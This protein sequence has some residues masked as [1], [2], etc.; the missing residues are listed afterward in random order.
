MR[1]VSRNVGEIRYA[2]QRIFSARVFEKADF[3]RGAPVGVARAAD[4]EDD[5]REPPRSRGVPRENAAAGIV[6]PRLKRFFPRLKNFRADGVPVSERRGKIPEK[7]RR[8]LAA[9]SRRVAFPDF[10]RAAG[11]DGVKRR[12][13]RERFRKNADVAERVQIR[14]VFAGNGDGDEAQIRVRAVG[15][16]QHARRSRIGKRDSAAVRRRDDA[17]RSAR[18]R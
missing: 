2:G 11:A 13:P 7:F 14:R 10:K 17:A 8:L 1:G 12:V 15:I 9:R 6:E 16:F 4:G 5:A 3:V 18:L